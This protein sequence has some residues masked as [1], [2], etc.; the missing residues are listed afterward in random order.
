M[1]DSDILKRVEDKLYN[2][3]LIVDVI[4]NE[5]DSTMQAVLKNTLIFVWGQVLKTSKLKLDGEIP[6]P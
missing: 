1:E 4:V 3:A 5:N 2:R 6:K